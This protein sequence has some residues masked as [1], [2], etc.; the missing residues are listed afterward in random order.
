MRTDKLD[1]YVDFKEL[2]KHLY[3]AQ[4]T[5]TKGDRV[6]MGNRMLALCEDCVSELCLA[7]DLK[8]ERMEHLQ[9]CIA[10]F[11]ALRL[12]LQTCV[13]LRLF[14]SEKATVGEDRDEK[15]GPLVVNMFERVANIDE[16]LGRWR[17]ATARAQATKFA[18]VPKE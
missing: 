5:M 7:N 12:N 4:F 3:R 11:T 1:I 17:S 6:V 2:H 10:L 15:L 18:S 8:E 16:G 14:K 9:R 13:D